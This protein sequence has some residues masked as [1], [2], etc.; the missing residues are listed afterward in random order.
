MSQNYFITAIGT[1]VGKTL[2]TATLA[3]QL[4]NSGQQVRALKPIISG[5]AS[6]PCDSTHLLEAQGVEVSDAA[7]AAISPWRF[8]APLSP[9]LAAAQEGRSID[10]LQLIDWCRTQSQTNTTTLI[11]GVGGIMVPLTEGYLLLDWM[12]Q[13]SWPV[14]LVASNYLGAI[15][16]TLLSLQALHQRDLVLHAV[17]I[18]ECPESNVSLQDTADSIEAFMPT[19]VPIYRFPWVQGGDNAWKNAPNLLSVLA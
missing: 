8:A 15:N 16:H 5:F 13:L 6:G 17:V 9:H 4:R 19:S 14:I 12:E 11:E 1:G 3:Y 7:I 10:T 2:L 18:S